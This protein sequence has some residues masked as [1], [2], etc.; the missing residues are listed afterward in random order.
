MAQGVNLAGQRVHR[1][2]VVEYSTGLVLS[3]RSGFP[4]DSL[5]GELQYVSRLYKRGS[6]GRDF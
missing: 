6:G 4:E 1:E 3:L 5:L 2:T